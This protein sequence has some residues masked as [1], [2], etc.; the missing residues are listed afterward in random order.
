MF[1]GLFKKIDQLITGRGKIDDD[2]YDDLEELLI[3]SDVGVHTTTRIVED[4]RQ[5]TRR[6][7]LSTADE[8]RAHLRNELSQIL[9]LGDRR[10]RV[11]AELPTVYLMVGVNGTGKTTTTAK[12]A[13]RLKS[14][15]KRVL[16]AAADTFRAA[17]IDQLEIWA[18][19]VSVDLVKHKEG[20]DPAAVVYDAIQAA[21]GRRMEYVLA[22]T[23]GRLHTKTNLMEELKKVHRVVQRELG[24]PADE[25]LLVL[26]ATIGQNAVNQA[27]SFAEALPLTGIALAKLDGTAR[28]GVVITVK[29]ELGIPIKLVGTGEKPGDL[30]EFRPEEFVAALFE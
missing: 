26:D 28:G 8:V 7:R 18:N 3:Q 14:Q 17:A 12:L 6:N 9:S 11:A 29:D 22:D 25:V 21:R 30:D 19:R 16:L 10:L 2:L 20:A 5:A 24:R 23:A 1:K 27:K 4:L 13:N 15:G